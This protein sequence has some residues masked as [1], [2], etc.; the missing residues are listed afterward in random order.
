MCT[1]LQV[2]FW[3]CLFCFCIFWMVSLVF[4]VAVFSDFDCLLRVGFYW[5]CVFV[6]GVWG[7]VV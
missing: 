7:C 5:L 3:C 6:F 1:G 4:V 2:E